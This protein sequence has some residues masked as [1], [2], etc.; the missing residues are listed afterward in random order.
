MGVRPDPLTPLPGLLPKHQNVNDD[1]PMAFADR[2][3]VQLADKPSGTVTS[4]ISKY[5]HY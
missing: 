5:G 4:H 2:L 3:K 1:S